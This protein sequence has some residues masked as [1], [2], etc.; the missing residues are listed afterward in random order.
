MQK[1][2]CC[3]KRLHL[4]PVDTQLANSQ[5]DVLPSAVKTI[6]SMSEMCKHH[7]VGQTKQ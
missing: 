7:F 5:S 6:I 2:A 1:E 3:I 4:I